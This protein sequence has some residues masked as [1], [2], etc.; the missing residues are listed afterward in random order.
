MKSIISHFHPSD[1]VPVKLDD[2][3]LRKVQVDATDHQQLKKEIQ[4]Q[5]AAQ[6]GRVGYGGWLEKRSLYA[7]NILFNKQYERNVHLGYDI[8]CDDAEAVVSPMDASVFSVHDNKG[9][10]DYGPTVILEHD[11]DGHSLYTLYGHL[12]RESLALRQKDELIKAG[13]IIGHVGSSAVNGNYVPH[14]HFQ[15]MSNMLG[16]KLDFPGVAAERDLSYYLKSVHHPDII[17]KWI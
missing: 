1:H 7:N 14:L 9:E 12:N 16:Y 4:R 2:D 5:V 3:H 6:N 8:W 13:D 17:L 11:V 15:L 10:G